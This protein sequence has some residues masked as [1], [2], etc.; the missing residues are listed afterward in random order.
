MFYSHLRI[1]AARRGC[2]IVCCNP[3]T[4]PTSK[5]ALQLMNVYIPF[6]LFVLSNFVL[7]QLLRADAVQ[8][9]R[10]ASG[11][12]CCWLHLNKY[13]VLIFC[14]V[15]VIG[16]WYKLLFILQSRFYLIFSF[17]L[18]TYLVKCVYC[19]IRDN[20]RIIAILIK[21]YKTFINPVCPIKNVVQ[22]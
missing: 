22:L 1:E 15:Y 14:I 3:T 6:K 9:L 4:R 16:I 2:I 7:Y 13:F 21:S 5:S 8:K 11:V 17:G 20:C 19:Q 18:K 10:C 12:L